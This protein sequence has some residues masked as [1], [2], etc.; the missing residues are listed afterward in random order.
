MVDSSIVSK[1]NIYISSKY[2]KDDETT[3]NFN[4]IIPDGMLKCTKDQYFSLNVNCF[5]CYNTFFNS[6]INSNKFQIIFK[7][8]DDSYYMIGNYYLNLGN[9]NIYDLLN[10]FNSKTSVYCNAT[11]DKV[12]NYFTFFRT[13]AQDTN[14]YNMYIKPINSS[15]FLGF[16][17][18]TENLISFVGTP[19]L[20]SINVNTITAL[21]ISI[22]GDISFENNNIDNCYGVWQNSDIILQKGVDVPKNGLIKYENIDGG[23]SFQYY[24]CNTDRIKY[25]SLSVFDQDMNKIVDMPDYLLHIQFNIR[26]KQHTNDLLKKNNDYTKEIYLI[27]GH[28]FEILIK[29]FNYVFKNN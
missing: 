16:K 27:M 14:Y 23:D 4:V 10:D 13:Y 22:D 8:S 9:P 6:N 19:S 26:N 7:R 12:T 24:L 20:L 5:Y 1:V 21:N 2:R 28:I 29:V 15:S 17:N 11:Y 18:N 25:F 3:S